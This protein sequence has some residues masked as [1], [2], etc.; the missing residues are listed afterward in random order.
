MRLTSLQ[1]LLLV[2]SQFDIRINVSGNLRITALTLVMALMIPGI[3]ILSKKLG[4]TAV[5][6]YRHTKGENRMCLQLGAS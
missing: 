5:Q 1:I 6:F 2:Y 3:E 4:C